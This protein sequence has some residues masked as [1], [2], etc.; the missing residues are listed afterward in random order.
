MQILPRT[1]LLPIIRGVAES[2]QPRGIAIVKFLEGP[3]RAT[4]GRVDFAWKLQSLR[5]HLGNQTSDKAAQVETITQTLIELPRAGREI[6]WRRNR[7]SRDDGRMRPC[8]T[9]NFSVKFPPRLKPISA[10]RE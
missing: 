2:V 9:R 5:F 1:R 3:Q 7:D 8:F 6:D 10:I 4:A